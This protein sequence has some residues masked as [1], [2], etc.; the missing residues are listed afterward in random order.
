MIIQRQTIYVS[1]GKVYKAILSIKVFSDDEIL[2]DLYGL[3]A[4]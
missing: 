3:A 2:A 4:C 1:L